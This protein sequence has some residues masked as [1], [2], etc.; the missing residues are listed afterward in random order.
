MRAE[1]FQNIAR[2]VAKDRATQKGLKGEVPQEIVKVFED[3]LESFFKDYLFWK[4]VS[5]VLSGKENKVREIAAGLEID[6]RMLSVATRIAGAKEE[7]QTRAWTIEYC[8]SL[9]IGPNSKYFTQQVKKSGWQPKEL[10]AHAEEEVKMQL[11]NRLY[12]L[13][14]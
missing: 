12:D 2:Q 14:L 11:G 8:L 7:S 10:D 9:V 13:L 6:F 4:R 3:I 5:E 1:I